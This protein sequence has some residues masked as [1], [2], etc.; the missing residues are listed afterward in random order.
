MHT[1]M[2][3]ECLIANSCRPLHVVTAMPSSL[4]DAIHANGWYQ[5]TAVGQPSV[6][7]TIAALRL[8]P[9]NLQP[10]TISRC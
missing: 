4:L 3:M 8:L 7:I 6:V 5:V 9:S 2:R 10:S 1:G